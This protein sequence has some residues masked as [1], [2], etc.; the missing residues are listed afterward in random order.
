MTKILDGND[1]FDIIGKSI[2]LRELFDGCLTS[3]IVTLSDLKESKSELF[4]IND[5]EKKSITHYNF[6]YDKKEEIIKY[7]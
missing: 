7:W 1:D 5:V 3:A 4:I 6:T 2:E